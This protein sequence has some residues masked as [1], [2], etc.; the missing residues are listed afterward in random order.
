M[1]NILSVHGT[2]ECTVNCPSLFHH[3]A[4]NV[5]EQHNFPILYGSITYTGKYSYVC[6]GTGPM[7][8]LR[9]LTLAMPFPAISSSVTNV[10]YLYIH[11]C[12]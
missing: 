10:L 9:M 2:L 4:E 6:E 3:I 7:A 11:E 12:R 8:A 1:I 5:F